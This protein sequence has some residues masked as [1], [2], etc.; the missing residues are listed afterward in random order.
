MRFHTA[1]NKYSWQAVYNLPLT[2]WK[3]FINVS[4]PYLDLKDLKIAI[5]L[6]FKKDLYENQIYNVLTLNCSV[7]KIIDIIEKYKDNVFVM[8][9]NGINR[10]NMEPFI[11]LS[12][13]FIKL[14]FCSNDLW[15]I[16]DLSIV[17]RYLLLFQLIIILKKI[18]N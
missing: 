8:T 11:V 16:R 7:K 18:M 10:I 14:S 17:Q 5:E 2:I 9:S 12:N 4:K 1:V 6:I 3:N 15:K 13:N